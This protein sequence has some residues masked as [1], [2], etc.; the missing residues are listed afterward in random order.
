MV[1]GIRER[2]Y[3]GEHDRQNGGADAER[4]QR[5]GNRDGALFRISLRILVRLS[6][7]PFEKS[8]RYFMMNSPMGRKIS[9]SFAGR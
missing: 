9:K 1:A 7:K 2:R 8:C 6:A 5:L 3:S 4:N